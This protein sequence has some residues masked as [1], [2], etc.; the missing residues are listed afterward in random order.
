MIERAHCFYDV[1]CNNLITYGTL[2]ICCSSSRTSYNY[3]PLG[4]PVEHDCG[5]SQRGRWRHT[6]V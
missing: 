5:A 3:R 4:A 6:D 1:L 2:F